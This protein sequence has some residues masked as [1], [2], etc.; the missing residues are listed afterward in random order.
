MLFGWHGNCIFPS[1][2]K[3]IQAMQPSQYSPTS[4]K[5][6]PCLNDAAS[7]G[8]FRGA[9]PPSPDWPSFG[10]KLPSASIAWSATP[11]LPPLATVRNEQVSLST[12]KKR[13]SHSL[14]SPRAESSSGMTAKGGSSFLP[15]KSNLAAQGDALSPSVSRGRGLL[16]S[17]FSGYILSEWHVKAAT[18]N[19]G[20]ILTYR[21]RGYA[22]V[23]VVSEQQGR[24]ACSRCLTKGSPRI[25]VAGM[26]LWPQLISFPHMSIAS[27]GFHADTCVETA[28]SRAAVGFR[29]TKA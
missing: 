11:F 27:C 29:S 26:E 18:S 3:G 9:I 1:A 24:Q 12:M 22:I 16:G 20:P 15:S 7:L 19:C 13:T 2:R 8:C 4:L 23:L 28:A 17:S 21:V 14:L 10:R 6:P 5:A 25:I